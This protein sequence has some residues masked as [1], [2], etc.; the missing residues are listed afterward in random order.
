MPKT[1]PASTPFTGIA[2]APPAQSWQDHLH[3]MLDAPEATTPAAP[4]FQLR[5]ARI[6]RFSWPGRHKRSRATPIATL[7]GAGRR[8]HNVCKLLFIQGTSRYTVEVMSFLVK[9]LLVNKAG[10]M[11]SRAD[12]PFEQVRSP[13]IATA[14]IGYANGV[15]GIHMAI[16]IT[17]FRRL[18]D[19][20][21]MFAQK[22]CV[23][24]TLFGEP[25]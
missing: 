8:L 13:C 12:T 15:L 5:K 14:L 4:L 25:L 10:V 23:R 17:L 19:F 20:A 18:H 21:E 22:G 6:R 9:R 7:Q 24:A 1:T 2:Q 3:S 11:Y 16:P